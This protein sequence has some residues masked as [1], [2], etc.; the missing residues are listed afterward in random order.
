MTT[1][2]S[3]GRKATEVMLA[4]IYPETTLTLVQ[5][6]QSRVIIIQNHQIVALVSA[7]IMK[8]VRAIRMNYQSVKMNVI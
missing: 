7:P 4:P 1:F 8:I 6:S 5:H 3:D 2:I